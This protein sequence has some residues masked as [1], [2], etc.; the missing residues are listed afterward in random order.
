VTDYVA[1]ARQALGRKRDVEGPQTVTA[2]EPAPVSETELDRAIIDTCISMLNR[3]GA[4]Q[5]VD[6]EGR[7]TI[8]L[9]RA[10]DT[11]EVRYAIRSLFPTSR[12][13][14]LEDPAVPARYRLRPPRTSTPAEGRGPLRN[15]A[16]I[17]VRADQRN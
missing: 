7:H 10:A 3:A 12:I 13:V 15:S 6:A 16:G 5:W 11:S 9:W 17:I 14:R 8:G 4:R 1:I 2:P